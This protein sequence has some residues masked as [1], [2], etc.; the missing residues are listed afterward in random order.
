MWGAAMAAA[1]VVLWCLPAGGRAQVPLA[2]PASPCPDVFQY[3]RGS[4][5][6]WR[7]QVWAWPPAR[8]RPVRLR[9][10]LFLEAALPNKYAGRILLLED[11]DVVARKILAGSRES[12]KYALLFPLLYPLPRVDRISVNDKPMCIGPRVNSPVLTQIALEH[13]LYPTATPLNSGTSI[14]AQG[15]FIPGTQPGGELHRPQPPRPQ[16]THPNIQTHPNYPNS[17]PAK[18]KP[19]IPTETKPPFRETTNSPHYHQTSSNIC[20]RSIAANELVFNGQGTARG[21][22]PWIAAMFVSPD[23]GNLEFQCSATLIN[24]KHVVTAGHCV[25]PKDQPEVEPHQIVVYLGIYNLRR[26][27]DIH[28]RAHEVEHI[29]VHPDYAKTTSFD[30]DVAVL[31]LII[32]AVYTPFIRPICLWAGSQ[33]LEAVVGMHGTVIG[34]G[35][36]EMGHKATNEPRQTQLPIVSQEEC[37]LSQPDFISI[38]SKRTFCAGFRNNSGPCNGDSGSGMFLRFSDGTVPRWYLRGITSVS[39]YDRQQ[40]RC[41]LLNYVVFTDMAKYGRWMQQFLKEEYK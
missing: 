31:R 36:D 24:K 17:Y 40:N 33:K 4:D 9:V 30:A 15:N 10:D 21:E 2:A 7:A 32:A 35:R 3:A 16:P 20:G 22:W 27:A 8:G 1:A 28:S 26:V 11:K 37:L 23:V 18:P 34:W 25:K 41:D 12:I 29:F 38:T 39:L 19:V 6:V 13:T 5:G 14:G